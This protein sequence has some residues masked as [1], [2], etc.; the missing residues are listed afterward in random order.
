MQDVLQHLITYSVVGT[1]AALPSLGSLLEFRISGPTS[2]LQNQN[3]NFNK[4]PR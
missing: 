1:L 4:I 2:D 3:F